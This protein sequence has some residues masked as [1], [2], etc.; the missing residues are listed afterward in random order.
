MA[1]LGSDQSQYLNGALKTMLK[2]DL[3]CNSGL[4]RQA[5]GAHQASLWEGQARYLA[6]MGWPASSLY[7]QD[8]SL[9]KKRKEKKVHELLAPSILV[10]F[11]LLYPPFFLLPLSISL[12]LLT[13]SFPFPF[14][15][16]L[17]G[18]PSSDSSPPPPPCLNFVSRFLNLQ[19]K[20]T[21]IYKPGDVK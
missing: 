12:L 6:L 19:I 5:P 4:F 7:T 18:V 9:V 17:L 14:S 21:L 16:F 1:S 20:L 3:F 10:S 2:G 8:I 13:L 15:V 11:Y